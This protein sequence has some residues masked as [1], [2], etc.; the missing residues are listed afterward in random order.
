MQIKVNEYRC[1]I[2]DRYDLK[3][4]SLFMDELEKWDNTVPRSYLYNMFYDE[5][6]LNMLLK[7]A[8]EIRDAKDNK[9][10]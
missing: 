9:Q 2:I 5:E 3:L 4:S 6:L 8:K 10:K 1:N 7:Q